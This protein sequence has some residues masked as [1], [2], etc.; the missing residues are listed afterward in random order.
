MRPLPDGDTQRAYARLAGAMYL[1][2]YVT[3]VFGYL[4]PARI[5]GTGDFAD[6]AQRVL[7]AEPLYRGALASMALGWVVIVLLAFSLYVALR[8]VHAR[9]AQLALCLE[10][11]QACV[12]AA[13]VMLSFAV[14]RLYTS[15]QAAGPLEAEQL[16]ALVR[17]VGAASD[18][19]F[20]IAMMFFAPGSLL[21]FWLF[22]RSGYI[23]RP[24]AALGVAGSALML[25]VSVG[26]LVAPQ[27]AGTFRW[28]AWAPMGLA[29]V[30]TALWLTVR[31]IRLE[32]PSRAGELA[33]A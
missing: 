19:G 6:R 16:R 32:P 3:S 14:L 26:G 1:L 22:Y 33:P 4:A 21:F 28:A 5:R 31:G 15:W 13:S 18:S 10:L 11:G 27:Q 23:P 25:L 30:G 29:E 12:G 2:N 9:L 17:V 7:D 24:L 20:N 8:P